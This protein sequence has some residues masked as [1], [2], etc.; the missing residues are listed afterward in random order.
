MIQPTTRF[1]QVRP[2][3]IQT[4]HVFEQSELA[5]HVQGAGKIST[6]HLNATF[7]N[8][9]ITPECLRALYKIGDAKADPGAPG[10]LGVNGFLEVMR[11]ISDPILALSLLCSC[12]IIFSDRGSCDIAIREA[13]RAW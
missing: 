1:G 8:S 2:Q 3:R 12:P 10:F 13:R 5:S 4:S 9:T 11:L 7:C 6:Q